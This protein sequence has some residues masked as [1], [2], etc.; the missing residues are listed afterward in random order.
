MHNALLVNELQLDNKRAA[1]AARADALRRDHRRLRRPCRRSSARSQK[2]AH[3]R[4]LRA[5]HRRDRH[6]Q[7]ADRARD[8]PPLAARAKGPFVTINCGAIPENLLESEL[9]GHVQGRLHRRGRQQA[10]QVP[11]GRR[12]HA[13]PRRDRR[14]AAQ[15]AGEAPARAAGAGRRHASATRA[16]EPVDIRVR[17]RDQPR[18]SRTRSSRAA[19]ARTSTTASTSSTSQ[20]PPLRERGDDVVVIAQVLPAALRPRVRRAR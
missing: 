9:F 10:R 5:H 2:I 14:D 6:R 1:R 11:G 3:H 8:P 19:S 4:H 7:G 20:L 12:R 17:R 15:P 13:L 16:P 18:C